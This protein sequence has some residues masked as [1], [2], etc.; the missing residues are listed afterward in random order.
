MSSTSTIVLLS[1]LYDISLVLSKSPT[2]IFLS[3]LIETI[4]PGTALETYVVFSSVLVTV[5]VIPRYA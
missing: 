1:F 5:K 2:L 4:V 3:P